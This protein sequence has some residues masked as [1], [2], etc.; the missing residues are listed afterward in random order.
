MATWF[1]WSLKIYLNLLHIY[2][3]RIE[4]RCKNRQIRPL[5]GNL[6]YKNYR[7][8]ACRTNHNSIDN[9]LLL[10]NF[11]HSIMRSRLGRWARDHLNIHLSS[12][13]RPRSAEPLGTV[14]LQGIS[15]NH[16]PWIRIDPLA[17][18]C[19]F[20]VHENHL[21]SHCHKVAVSLS[22]DYL[23]SGHSSRSAGTIPRNDSSGLD[24]T[25]QKEKKLG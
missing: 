6:P 22:Y 4:R 11:Y 9:T 17:K 14:D 2:Y 21:L 7:P 5:P 25:D 15:A 12:I 10:R 8:V 19:L 1:L 18:N 20:N 16:S 3:N 23:L 13:S 24:G